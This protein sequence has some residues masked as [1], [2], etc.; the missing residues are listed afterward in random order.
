MKLGLSTESWSENGKLRS[1]DGADA[2]WERAVQRETEGEQEEE[3]QRESE[4][5]FTGL[6]LPLPPCT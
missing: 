3:G 2:M 1:A 6:S 5:I 4:C